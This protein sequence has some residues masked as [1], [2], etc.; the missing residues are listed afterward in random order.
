MLVGAV[1][2][3]R[4]RAQRRTVAGDATVSIEGATYEVEPELAGETVTLLWG[5]FDQ[6]LFVE[7][8]GKRFG[9]FQPSRGAVPLFRYRKHQKS[10]QEERL[11]K[12]V[13]LA[14]QL[15]LPRAAVTGGDRPLPSLPLSAR[16]LAVRTTPFPE[17]VVE[18][19]FPTA[20]AARHAIAVQLR[21][22]LGSLPEPDR[23]FISDLLAETLDKAIIADRV[24]ER[25]Q[26]RRGTS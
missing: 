8:A 14:D 11:D 12:V 6:E 9:P 1:L 24:R 18:I 25:L 3:V 2:R 22:P 10:R 16:D 5:L 26:T 7:H 23:R 17:A 19:T 15:G 13:K 21:R 20:L 4:A